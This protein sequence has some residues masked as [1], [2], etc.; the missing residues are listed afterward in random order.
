MDCSSCRM[1]LLCD[2]TFCGQDDAQPWDVYVI[3]TT[4]LTTGDQGRYTKDKR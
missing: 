3:G 2:K 1:Y 4:N